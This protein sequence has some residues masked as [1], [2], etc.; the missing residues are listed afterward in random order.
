MGT[1]R[2]M[3]HA[4]RA[5]EFPS[6]H[7]KISF[8]PLP[9]KAEVLSYLRS[10]TEVFSMLSSDYEIVGRTRRLLGGD[11][12]I[13]DGQHLW[14]DD[15][16]FYF[17]THNVEL[18][19]G[20]LEFIRQRS[21]T[22]PDLEYDV[23]VEMAER[24]GELISPSATGP[25]NS[26]ERDS[27]AKAPASPFWG[28]MAQVRRNP[29]DHNSFQDAMEILFFA[30]LTQGEP[31]HHSR[32]AV[33]RMWRE[34]HAFIHV[35]PQVMSSFLAWA[36]NYT[37]GEYRDYW[38]RACYA[39]SILDM[40]WEN[41]LFADCREVALAPDYPEDIE[42]LMEQTAW[43]KEPLPAG[44]V[45]ERVPASHWWWWAPERTGPNDPLRAG[46]D[47]ATK[48]SANS[49]RRLLLPFLQ[50]LSRGTLTP[51][52]VNE[53]I[54]RL[55]LEPIARTIGPGRSGSIAHCS[56]AVSEDS[57]L[58]V[59]LGR[60]GPDGWVMTLLFEGMMPAPGIASRYRA[61][62][63]QLIEY[64][65]LS[66]IEIDPPMQA[67]EVHTVEP[68]TPE[69]APIGL[70]WELPYHRLADMWMH[71]GLT[72][73]APDEVKKVKLREVT[74]TPIWQV[75]PQTLRDEATAFLTED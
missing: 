3:F 33:Q 56:F 26:P 75:A 65:G 67:D 6:I 38:Y 69:P 30:I 27:L 24:A 19:S 66:L 34:L 44:W 15:L 49:A 48:S 71:I 32:E 43:G 37:S 8:T 61:R 39:R 29:R 60:V 51:A 9:D 40:V 62:F 72:D 2:E 50:A 20:F 5:D 55:G 4:S 42:D 63:R 46:T 70:S 47:L 54:V 13:T 41:P 16:V 58:T 57:T 7:D 22:V 28:R 31:G 12:V 52:Q 25:E 53:L 23:L 64:F 74:R 10:G 11:S 21:Y 17:D 36:E 73:D 14:R 35:N 68:A 45:P 59:D 1:F 18:P